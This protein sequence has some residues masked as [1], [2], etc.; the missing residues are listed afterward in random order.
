MTS[1]VISRSV[2]RLDKWIHRQ[3]SWIQLSLAAVWLAAGISGWII[4]GWQWAAIG[5]P[6]IVAPPALLL[7]RWTY[8]DQE[9]DDGDNVV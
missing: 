2:D 4:Y 1:P 3:A 8:L 5:L 9:N 6:V 7:F